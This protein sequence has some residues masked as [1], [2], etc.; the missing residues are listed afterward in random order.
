MA[1]LDP[2]AWG[3]PAGCCKMKNKARFHTHTLRTQRNP[4]PG[5]TAAARALIALRHAAVSRQRRHRHAGR[6]GAPAAALCG[7]PARRQVLG[8]EV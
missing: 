5:L 2:H 6:L 1:P 3:V 4:N 7:V 8:E